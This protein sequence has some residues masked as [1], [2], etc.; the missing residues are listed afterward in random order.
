MLSHD[1]GDIWNDVTTNLPFPV[2]RFNAITFAG[3]NVYVATDKGVVRSN[4]GI[5]WHTLIDSEGTP[6]AM[7]RLA[8]DDTTVY[9]EFNHK[10]YQ[11]HRDTGKWQQVTPEIPHFIFS[12][13][14]DGGT[15]YVGTAGRGVL[16]F[17]LD[18]STDR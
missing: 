11:L 7:S 17:S 5:K 10:I 4:N 16:R 18:D 3:Q 14:V 6:L 9:G 13:D 2:E 8:V 1:E 12:F 15:L